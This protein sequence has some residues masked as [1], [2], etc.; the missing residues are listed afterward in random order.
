M[1]FPSWL[2][3]PPELRALIREKHLGPVAQQMLRRTC[4]EE[5][6]CTPV[7]KE[8]AWIV[9]DAVREGSLPICQYLATAIH[10]EFKAEQASRDSDDDPPM[11]EY[12]LYSAF[13]E[14][15]E[16]GH[17]HTAAWA[18]EQGAL[19]GLFSLDPKV[20]FERLA[21]AGN[22]KALEWM[23][24]NVADC[25]PE[26]VPADVTDLATARLLVGLGLKVTTGNA[27]AWV[28]AGHRAD[29][30]LA[31]LYPDLQKVQI[32]LRAIAG[33]GATGGELGDLINEDEDTY[34]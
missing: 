32:R 18:I 2:A 13:E 6:S 4:K 10:I 11:L 16:R 28:R 33:L 21:R 26:T 27:I 29:S 25:L 20:E 1:S 24:A 31:L 23:A 30:F 12:C 5:A 9:D 17:Y 19:D 34:W 15:L 3:L 8:E 7:A 14:A 22:V